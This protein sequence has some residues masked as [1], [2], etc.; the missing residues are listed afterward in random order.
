MASNADQ[1]LGKTSF[2]P[3]WN[4]VHED[5]SPFPGAEH[6]VPTSIRTR[7]AVRDVVMG[8]YRPKRRDRVW[9]LVDAEPHLDETGQVL[10]V[11][12][13]FSDITEQRRIQTQAAAGDRLASMGRLAAGVA[14]EI[15]NPLAY[16]VGHL[17]LLRRAALEPPL[18]ASVEQALEG[19]ER[20]RAIVEDLRTL[21]RGDD[22]N[23][24]P[25]DLLDVVRSAARVAA[26]PVR[27]RARIATDLVPVP[28]V[29]GNN[30]R[31][32]QLVLNLLM[33]AAE[34]LPEGQPERNEIRIRVRP[35]DPA[36]VMLEVS[37]TGPGIAPDV[38][39]R[40]FDPFFTTKPMGAGTGLGLAIC[41][42]ITTSI[43][44][45]IDVES[46]P[47]R[48]ATFFVTLK[49]STQSEAPLLAAPPTSAPR[50]CVL[51]ID[52]E[53]RLGQVMAQ[54][55]APKHD[56]HVETRA[57][58]AIER[59]LAGEE[60]DVVF[61]DLTMPDMSGM[62]FYDVIEGRLPLL[63]RR[64]VFMTGGAFT[65]RA[66][67]FLEQHADRVLTKPFAPEE[68]GSRHRAGKGAYDSTTDAV[69]EGRWAKSSF[70]RE[71]R[72]SRVAV[73]TKRTLVRRIARRSWRTSSPGGRTPIS[74]CSGGG[75]VIRS[76]TSRAG[77][78]T[79]SCCGSTGS[80]STRR[81]SASPVRIFSTTTSRAGSARRRLPRSA[82]PRSPGAGSATVSRSSS[83]TGRSRA[84]ISTARPRPSS[85]SRR[86]SSNQ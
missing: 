8:V 66:V 51:L 38:I 33:N 68:M 70:E 62:D 59:L 61:C 55:L 35:K 79:A 25:V 30:A 2:D 6:P 64:I 10:H 77:S 26:G 1:L 85:L 40:I 63:A 67:A 16:V 84:R 18:G 19:A 83:G 48:G 12:C 21:S 73:V 81:A 11:V 15:N 75:C 32:G 13:T 71:I 80:F 43:G 52:D 29:E 7:R 5:G 60:F 9:L 4:V 41:H 57:A 36:H 50:S 82:P 20:V 28:M 58:T 56:V 76:S 47:G 65:P 86:T 69:R 53:V 17:E 42:G 3:D 49:V 31:L 37:D 44:G 74:S 46:T 23:R 24:G 22:E 39:E 45:R 27:H 78:A 34:A 54:L 72:R 14:H